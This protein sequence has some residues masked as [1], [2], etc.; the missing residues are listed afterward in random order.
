MFEESK[1]IGAINS[2]YLWWLFFDKENKIINVQRFIWGNNDQ[3]TEIK[4]IWF[5][6]K[7]K[8]SNIVET[9]IVYQS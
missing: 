7:S 8:K 5:L 2:R 1:F 9:W 6:K 4:Y 3:M